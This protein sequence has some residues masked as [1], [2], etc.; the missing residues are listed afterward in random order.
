MRPGRKLDD[1]E[2]VARTQEWL[3]LEPDPERWMYPLR[4]PPSSSLYQSLP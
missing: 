3:G 1:R 4:A 2:R